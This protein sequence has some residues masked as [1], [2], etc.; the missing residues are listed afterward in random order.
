MNTIISDVNGNNVVDSDG[1]GLFDGEE[2]AQLTD[3]QDANH[4]MYKGAEDL[5]GDG[6]RNAADTDLNDNN[7]LM[8]KK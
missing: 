2:F 8:I 1:D 3:P 4:P 5:D 7:I 6:I